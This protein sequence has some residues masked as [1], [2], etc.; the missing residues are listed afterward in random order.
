MRVFLLA[1]VAVAIAFAGPSAADNAAADNLGLL[2]IVGPGYNISLTDAA[3]DHVSHL[4]PGTYS[5]VVHDRSDIHDFHLTGPGVDARTDIDFVGD[6]TFTI[7]VT[8]GYYTYICDAHPA[9]MIGKFTGGNPPAPPV[10]TSKLVSAH[11]GPGRTLAFP[12][13]LAAGKYAVTV[14][15]LSSTDNLHL[16]GPGVNRKTGVA[17]KGTVKWTLTLKPGT[18]RAWSDAHTTL[19]RTITVR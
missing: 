9:T 13:K 8:D 7:S 5:L 4:D 17:F 2:G 1:A 12:A 3:G 16:K 18:Y 6:Q 19:T 10:G 14:R 11:V 15:D